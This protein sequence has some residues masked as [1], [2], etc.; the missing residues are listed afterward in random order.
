MDTQF[1]YA[2]HHADR[3]LDELKEFL[4]IPSIGTLNTHADDTRRAAEWL[5]DHCL[6]VGMA[7]AELMETP[8]HPIVYA[9]WLEAGPDAPTV[10]VYG[11]YDVQPADDPRNE[12]LS[13]A[14]EPVIR[15]GNIYARGAIDDK[16]QLFMHLKVFEG[17][18]QSEGRFPVNIKMMFEGEEESGSTNLE[19]FIRDHLDLLA[20]DVVVISDT[21]MQGEDS[22]SMDYGL[23]GLLYTEITI[24]GLR[25]DLHSGYGGTVPNPA[26]ALVQ[27]LAKMHDANGRIQVPGFYDDVQE[28]TPQERE[29]LA[30]NPITEDDWKQQRGVEALWGEPGY[31]FLER[32]GARPTLEINGLVSGWTGQGAKTVIGADALAKVSC[33][34]VPNQDPQKILQALKDYVRH[35]TPPGLHSEVR[36]LGA[37]APGVVVP[38]DAPPMRAAREAMTATFGREPIM[39]RNGGTIPVVS[40]YQELL[41]VPVLLIGFGLPDDNLHAPNE[42]MTLS[43]FFKGIDTLAL[44]YPRLQDAM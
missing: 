8:G 39:T 2:Q 10:L 16:G 29:A 14:F 44:F 7:R 1:A 20:C 22:P 17:L 11:H 28:L 41:N 31:T 27:I 42:K 15:D 36:P 38:I 3:I 19:P 24:T 6:G 34:L 21:A 32:F 40:L 30:A 18:M 13:R 33:R 9:E 43:M 4:R 12:W 25:T 5:R 37:S 23:R 35:L 26:Q